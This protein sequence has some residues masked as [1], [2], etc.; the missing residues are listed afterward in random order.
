MDDYTAVAEPL[1]AA[2]EGR[3]PWG[4][5]DMAKA[6]GFVILLTILISVPV[7]LIADEV[8]GGRDVEDDATALSIVLGL[9]VFL[10]GFMLWMA[11]RFS[12]RKYRLDFSALGLRKPDRGTW[13]MPFGI[14]FTSLAVMYVYFGLLSAA[15]VEPET[16]LPDGV[17]DNAGPF[18]VLF[19][20][21]VFVAPP[22]E[23]IFFRGFIF[24]GLR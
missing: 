23:E 9:T 18:L 5:A 20:I 15:G 21:S 10:E 14:L 1:P 11:Y 6:I 22:V 17:F 3:T 19:F 2:P 16:D 13:M 8:A 7:S 4:L 12:V 24:G